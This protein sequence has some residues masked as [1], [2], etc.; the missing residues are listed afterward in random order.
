MTA[1]PVPLSILAGSPV[2][3]KN[4]H[5]ISFHCCAGDLINRV[6]DHPYGRLV[7]VEL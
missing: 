3:R 2:R 1:I 5:A 4:C 7:M 6:S